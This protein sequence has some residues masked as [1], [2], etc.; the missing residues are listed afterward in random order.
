MCGLPM[1]SVGSG[2]ARPRRSCHQAGKVRF[3]RL[4]ECPEPSVVAGRH[5]GANRRP[6]RQRLAPGHDLGLAGEDAEIADAVEGFEPSTPTLARLRLLGIVTISRTPTTR[7]FIGL[8]LCCAC[9][10]TCQ[11][12]CLLIK[13]RASLSVAKRSS[14]AGMVP[15]AAPTIVRSRLK[16]AYS[17]SLRMW[18]QCTSA[19]SICTTTDAT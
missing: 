15:S 3:P 14:P 9:A 5:R 8:S 2:R 19:F 10:C 4:E 1:Q 16:L 7:H 18:L 11:P 6:C 12:N 13:L 17:F